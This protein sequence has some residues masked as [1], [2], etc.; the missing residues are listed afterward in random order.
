M[1]PSVTG[2]PGVGADTFD[3]HLITESGSIANIT[4]QGNQFVSSD[5]DRMVLIQHSASPL[6][7]D[8]NTTNI[9]FGFA[10]T[11][12]M[13]VMFFPCSVNGTTDECAAYGFTTGLQIHATSQ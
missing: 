1:I 5:A 13:N 10:T 7:I 12:R 2:I 9:D 8:E 3:A 11:N 6:V 4:S